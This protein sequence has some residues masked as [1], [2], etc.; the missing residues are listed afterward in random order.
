VFAA[1]TVSI[2][3]ELPGRGMTRVVPAFLPED[4]PIYDGT[5]PGGAFLASDQRFTVWL[6]SRNARTLATHPWRFFDGEHCYPARRSLALTDPGISAGILGIPARLLTGDPVATFNVV[7]LEIA[8]IA[9]LGMY[10][11]V[12]H[13]TAVPAAGILA[14]LLFAFHV[15]KLWNVAHPY[16]DDSGWMVLAALFATR[17][18]ERGRWRDAIAFSTCAALQTA[19]S[20]YALLAA[21]F[22]CSPLGVW[23]PARFGVRRLRPG[24]VVFA[25]GMLAATGFLVFSPFLA[26]RSEGVLSARGAQM[27]YAWSSYLP[28]GNLFPGWTICALLLAAF[29]L[30]RRRAVGAGR[31]DPRF[32]LAVG[33]L[34]ALAAATGGSDGEALRRAL[35]AEGPPL[36]LPNLYRILSGFI[37]GL[38]VVRAPSTIH[39]GVHVGWCALA[40]FGAAAVIRAAGAR[41]AT[42]AA[43]ALLAVAYVD[44]LRPRSLGLEPRLAYSWFEVRP[45]ERSLA[46]FRELEALG[47]AGPVLEVPTTHT[48]QAASAAILLTEYHGRRTSQCYGSFHPPVSERVRELGAAMPAPAAAA[49]LRE[50]G[51]RTVLVHHPTAF[52]APLRLRYRNFALRQPALLR[53][54]HANAWASAYAIGPFQEAEEPSQRSR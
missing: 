3:H 40:G 27:H 23:L 52:H 12:R 36:P 24:Q 19:A 49:E 17:W 2:F 16:I 18:F 8:W 34:L 26:W 14:G 25:L 22:V 30:G 7:W 1:A 20:F 9:A 6:V 37:P 38:E 13:W 4:G 32:A 33:T 46:F 31:G 21:V 53:G 51:F 43:L 44:Q 50:L 41:F 47:S 11:L 5:H 15:A 35:T 29:A 10:L 54:Q 48:P 45:E 42:W 28:G 39:S